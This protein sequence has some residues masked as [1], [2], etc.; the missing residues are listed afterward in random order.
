V[1]YL[2]R[3]IY[4]STEEEMHYWLHSNFCT[5]LGNIEIKE[6]GNSTGLAS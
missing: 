5:G 2:Q 1:L 4:L 3:P 6:E